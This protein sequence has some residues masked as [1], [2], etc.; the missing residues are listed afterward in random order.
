MQVIVAGAGPGAVEFYTEKM[1]TAVAA[2]DVVITSERLAEPMRELNDN[3]VVAGVMETVDYLRR[4]ASSDETVCVAASGDT[5]F[6]SIA[7]TIGKNLPEGVEAEF[8]CGISSMQY[9]ASVTGIGYE[10]MKLISLH[11]K[12]GSAV[13]FVCYNK[14]VFALTG[15]RIKAEDVIQELC[16]AGL[17]QVRVHVGEALTAENQRLLS[18]TA[19][20][21]S[22]E[23]FDDLTVMIIENDHAADRYRTL[24]DADFVRGRTPM[25]KAAVRDLSV[26]R[27]EIHPDDGA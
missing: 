23:N 12:N 27:L 26:A 16:D 18:G 21:L 15:G 11:G 7:S 9:F 8:L 1:K 5:G 25:T 6:Y 22:G 19:A 20:E 2:A 4:N 14:K 24:S 10:D 13:P 3:V 17:D